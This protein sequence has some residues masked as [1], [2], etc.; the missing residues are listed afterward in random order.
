MIY[1][2]FSGGICMSAVLV[3]IVLALA[4]LAVLIA[5]VRSGRFFAAVIGSVVQGVASLP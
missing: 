5:F 1:K 2:G 3:S 4:A